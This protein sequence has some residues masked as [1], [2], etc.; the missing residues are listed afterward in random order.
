MR[1]EII[2][3]ETPLPEAPR[4]GTVAWLTSL[5]LATRAG[6]TVLEPTASDLDDIGPRGPADAG[7]F[8]ARRSLL[9]HVI[10]RRLDI[11]PAD[12]VVRYGP[13]GRPSLT[14]PEHELFC[15]VA[16]RG[17]LVGLAVSPDPVGLDL[18]PIE[19][20]PV[21]WTMLTKSEAADLLLLPEPDRLPA[22]LA[23]W[24]VKEAYLKATGT[25]LN[26]D[27]ATLSVGF[28]GPHATIEDGGRPVML[29]ATGVHTGEIGGRRLVA[30]C[31]ALP[32][33]HPAP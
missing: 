17:D 19:P 1:S 10:A 28:A 6:L 31:I 7:R 21:P 8:L 26:V 24:T 2:W 33:P 22:F 16:G 23:I 14:L 4:T 25:G 18:E 9:R 13:H 5:A 12:V 11:A 15:S 30:T 20:G 27:P 29:R 3:R 32:R